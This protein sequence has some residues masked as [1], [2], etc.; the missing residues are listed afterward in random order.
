MGCKI[1]KEVSM[2]TIDVNRVLESAKLRGPTLVV[3]LCAAS[4]LILDGF[5]IQAAG[6]A[7]PALVGDLH[8]KRAALGPALAA[9]LV[10]MAIGAASIGALGDRWGRRRTLLLSTALFGVA[11]LLAA[12]ATSVATLAVWR[13]ITGIGLGGALTTATALIAEFSPRR[14]RSQAIGAIQVGVPIGGMLGAALA[15]EIMPVYGW[16]SVF[17][18]GGVLPI[19]AA[20]I[21]YFVLP[22]SP[23][24]LAARRQNASGQNAQALAA[25]L[26]KIDPRGRYEATDTFVQ[27]GEVA[28]GR[29]GV[30]ALFSP[31]LRWDTAIV[32]LAFLTNMYAVYAFFSW[33]PLVL[34][35]LGFEVGTAV[36]GALVFNVAG[37]V[38]V[39]AVSWL[40]ARFGSR[41]PLAVCAL[42]AAASLAWLAWFADG[43][44]ALMGGIAFAGAA[45][46]A[47]QVGMYAVAV[48]VFPTECRTSG[49]GWV[50]GTGRVGGIASSLGGGLLL[51]LTGASGFFGCIAAVLL[52]TFASVLAV[53]RQITSSRLLPAPG[54][55]T[56]EPSAP[57]T[58]TAGGSLRTPDPSYPPHR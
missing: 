35:S 20:A 46:S 21:M 53:R 37:I 40:I 3:L 43:L 34:T 13:F 28:T 15:A 32:S 10:G 24:F 58:R 16:R 50:L 31:Q 17:V 42:V 26:A 12:T 7:A 18:I 55:E 39:I 52:F 41:R 45:V 38:G 1:C 2:A 44:P 27:S 14:F 54:P 9:S 6:F 51:T 8:V 36:K 5:D 33:A 22:E 25:L 23:R 29:S 19:L 48:H 49:V 56:A 47:V 30:G 4:S 11:T 57:D